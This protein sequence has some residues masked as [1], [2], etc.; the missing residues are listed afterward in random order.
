M[1]IHMLRRFRGA[2]IHSPSSS[3]APGI[4]S[5][6]VHYL[7]LLRMISRAALPM[8]SELLLEALH[9][10][11]DG[12]G[13]HNSAGSLGQT[14]PHYFQAP[15]PGLRMG[16]PAF[17]SVS[18]CAAI[19]QVRNAHVFLQIGS[20]EYSRPF[21]RARSDQRDAQVERLCTLT[22][23]PDSLRAPPDGVHDAQAATILLRCEVRAVARL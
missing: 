16:H 18:M 1:K 13:G 7:E 20:R 9:Q 8:K 5:F 12:S 2:Y 6:T 11:I 22:H 15:H 10:G 19:P 23:H 21:L 3:L 4:I 14:H 17:L